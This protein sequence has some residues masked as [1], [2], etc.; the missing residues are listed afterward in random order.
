METLDKEIMVALLK[1]QSS[2]YE[3]WHETLNKKYPYATMLR[4]IKDLE[5]SCLVS[6]QKATRKNGKPDNR[7]TVRLTLTNFGLATLIIKGNL[8]NEEYKFAGAKLL[9]KEFP[10]IQFLA[11]GLGLTSGDILK[12]IFEKIRPKMNLDYFNKEYFDEIVL[13]SFAETLTETYRNMTPP[14]R[15]KLRQIVMQNIRETNGKNVGV[16][17]E[18]TNEILNVL[19]KHQRKFENLIRTCKTGLENIKK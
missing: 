11:R 18:L 8:N 10:Q 12:D 15:E 1:P 5:K 2:I 16:T 3:L 17:S 13:I 6:T 4:H 19:E 9:P 14:K 7:K